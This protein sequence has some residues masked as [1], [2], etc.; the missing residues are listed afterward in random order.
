[1]GLGSMRGWLANISGRPPTEDAAAAINVLDVRVRLGA[2]LA[3]DGVTGRFDPGSLT[4]V[5]GPNGAGKSTLLNVLSGLLRPTSGRVACPARRRNRVAYLPQQTELDRDFPMTVA[6]LVALG[7]WR[8]IGAYRDLSRTAGDRVTDAIEA[9]GLRESRHRRIGDLSVGQIR[10]AFFARLLLQDVEVILL[11]EPFAAVDM[12]TVETLL[13]LIARWHAEGRTIVAVVHDMHQ[14]RAHF[15]SALVLS[16]RPVAWGDTGA[17]LT[18][19]NLALA[20]AVA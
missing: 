7:L 20:A 8:T 5:V 3:L 14:V 10:R 13:T 11:D 18:E 6:E 12:R 19:D 1:M 2:H 9:V 16:R 15:P 17:V 4:A